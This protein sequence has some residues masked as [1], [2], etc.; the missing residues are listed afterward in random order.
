MKLGK[1]LLPICASALYDHDFSDAELE[2][3]GSLH[4]EEFLTFYPGHPAPHE[5]FNKLK[6]DYFMSGKELRD[7]KASKKDKIAARQVTTI[8]FG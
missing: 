8:Y 6:R 7:A 3:L 1:F 5:L 4:Y 2:K